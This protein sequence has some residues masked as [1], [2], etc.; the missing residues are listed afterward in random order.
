MCREVGVV[1]ENGNGHV[2]FTV[3]LI[4][5]GHEDFK[6]HREAFCQNGALKV[7]WFSKKV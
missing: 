5:E 2:V 3:E 6:L 4:C 7:D 1:D